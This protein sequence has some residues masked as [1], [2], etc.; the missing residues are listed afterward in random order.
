MSTLRVN[1]LLTADGAQFNRVMAGAQRTVASLGA[2]FAAIFSVGMISRF[3]WSTMQWAGRMTDLAARTGIAVEE[4][5]RME[6]AAK[7][8][9]VELDSMVKAYQMIEAK[10][11]A[12]LRGDRNAMGSFAGFGISGSDLQNKSGKELFDSIA[13][14]LQETKNPEAL[15]GPLRDV[16]GRQGPELIEAFATYTGKSMESLTVM[17]SETAAALDDAGDKLAEF[18]RQLKVFTANLLAGGISM[19]EKAVAVGMSLFRFLKTGEHPSGVYDWLMAAQKTGEA[20]AAARKGRNVFNL[21]PFIAPTSSKTAA[22]RMKLYSD[23]LLASGNFLGQAGGAVASIQQRQLTIMQRQLQV[24]TDTYT[25]IKSM[26]RY[27]FPI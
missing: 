1:A 7:E 3:A 16:F 11:F 13:R 15:I 24:Q 5:Q 6:A 25:A 4:L 9:G 14:V 8:T 27:E 26:V 20:Q 21:D 2:Q 10:R 12:A 22:E 18:G 23:P 17:S 19:S